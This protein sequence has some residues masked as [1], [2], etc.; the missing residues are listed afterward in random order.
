MQDSKSNEKSRSSLQHNSDHTSCPVCMRDFKDQQEIDD[1]VTELKNYSKKL[2][3]KMLAIDEKIKDT[4]QKV[5]NMIK[6]K[7][8]KEVYE[9][10]KNHDLAE[11][12]EQ[13]DNLDRNV[14]PKIKKDLKENNDKIKKIE[15]VKSYSESIQ[16]EVVIVDKYA[17]EIR[18]LDQKILQQKSLLGKFNSKI[19]ILSFQLVIKFFSGSNNADNDDSDSEESPMDR[20][21]AKKLLLQ[22]EMQ[23]INNNI[24]SNQSEINKNYV[25]QDKINALKEKLNILKTRR[26]ELQA[27]MQKK[28]QLS[29]KQDELKQEIEQTRVEIKDLKEK[30]Q[31]LVDKITDLSLLKQD[32]MDTNKEDMDKRVK[33]INELQNLNGLI[34]D[35]I[36]ST[37]NYERNESSEFEILKFKFSKR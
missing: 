19:L 35:L 8:T 27:K 22:Q 6:M 5:L 30:I 23:D 33:K 10:I 28:T 25:N 15:S 16:N 14:T 13:M 34:T 2:P 18:S 9:K 37:R 29:E 12:R 3:K 11:L 36:T 24:E 32:N 21:K 31:V 1:T 26:N 17:N 20:V 7:P 4:E